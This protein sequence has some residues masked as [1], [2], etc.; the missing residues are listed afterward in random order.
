MQL[1]GA[2][3]AILCQTLVRTADGKGRV[4]AV[5]ILIATPAIRNLI[6]EGKTHQ[7]GSALQAGA[8]HGMISDGPVARRARA[9]AQDHL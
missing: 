2:L 7:I 4:A 6:R 5:E 1:A 3:Q 9:P 8:K